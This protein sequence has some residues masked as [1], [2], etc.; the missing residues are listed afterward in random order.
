M[1]IKEAENLYKKIMG[2]LSQGYVKDALDNLL[3]L[4]VESQQS[5]FRHQYEKNLEIYKNIL[6]YT[7]E[8]IDDPDRQKIYDKMLSS[9]FELSDLVYQHLLTHRPGMQIYQIKKDFENKMDWMIDLAADSIT[10]L[11]FET[12]LDE[13]LKDLESL[14]F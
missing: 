14:F 13:L 9:V 10:G 8:G 1:T 2:D 6:K 5:E 4:I 11:R 12:D 3:R 7:A